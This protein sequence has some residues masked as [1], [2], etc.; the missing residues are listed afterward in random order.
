MTGPSGCMANP[1][2]PHAVATDGSLAQLTVELAYALPDRQTLLTLSV[3]AGSTVEAAIRQSGLLQ[4]HPEIDLSQ[5]P[6][7]IWSRLVPLQQELCAGDRIEIYRPLTV[8][9]ATTLRQREQA[10]RRQRR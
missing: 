3:P 2:E 6:V 8:D 5:Q 10:K 4:R 7:G 9:P 1:P